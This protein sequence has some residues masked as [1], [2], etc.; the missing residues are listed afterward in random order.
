V[1]AAAAG[2]SRH[3]DERK[4]RI[5][6][7]SGGHGVDLILDS[8]GGAGFAG[9]FEHVAPLGLVILYGSLGGWPDADVVP[10]MR[11]LLESGRVLGKLVLKP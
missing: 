11:A 8:V 1:D 10:A 5:A 2:D 3:R 6:A 4:E 9:L 7:A